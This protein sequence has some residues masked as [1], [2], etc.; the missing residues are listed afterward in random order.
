MD[1][2]SIC[3]FQEVDLDT[4][5]AGL[6]GQGGPQPEKEK[7]PRENHRLRRGERKKEKRWAALEKGKKKKEE[8]NVGRLGF[9][10]QERFRKILKFNLFPGLI[11]IQT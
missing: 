6:Q 9:W 5:V 8:S 7:G 10:V 11:Q 1:M 4:G 2:N 3:F